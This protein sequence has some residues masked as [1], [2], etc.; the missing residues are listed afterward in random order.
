MIKTL[1]YHQAQMDILQTIVKRRLQAGD[2]LPSLREFLAESEFSEITLRRALDDLS[3]K[4]VIEKRQG[5]GSFLR[6]NMLGSALLGHIL[7]INIYRY[8]PVW[9]ASMQSMKNYLEERGLGLQCFAET[10]PTPEITEA[11]RTCKGIM[12]SGWLTR[13]WVDYLKV[14]GCPLMVIGPNPFE[15]EIPSMDWNWAAGTKQLTSRLIETGSRKIGLLIVNLEYHSSI[16]TERGFFQALDFHNLPHTDNPVLYGNKVNHSN[17]ED[18]INFIK[19]YPQLDTLIIN[20][21]NYLPVLE[22]IIDGF[23]SPNI[24]LG[25]IRNSEYL[26]KNT[27]LLVSNGNLHLRSAEVFW[28]AL[29]EPELLPEL[30][31]AKK[32]EN[33]F[34]IIEPLEVELKKV[35]NCEK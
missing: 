4:G 21:S 29:K 28:E 19:Q 35:S 33:T 26:M 1:K 30:I 9:T 3:Q 10:E 5:T 25:V 13:E 18:I 24:R 32:Q 14:P 8:Y 27:F 2:R 34:K 20:S 16:Q 12:A 7:Y 22:L 6:K 17:H 31:A 23:I 11:A 15:N